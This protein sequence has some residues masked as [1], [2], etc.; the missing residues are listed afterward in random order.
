MATPV[1][2]EELPPQD[3]EMVISQKTRRSSFCC[4]PLAM[5]ALALAGVVSAQNQTVQSYPLN[6]YSR[7]LD[8]QWE[9]IKYASDGNV[10]FASSSQS[11]HH[12]ASFF[13]YSPAT[14]QVTML[15]EDITTICGEDPQTNP[16]GKIHANIQ[17]MHGWLFFTTHFGADDRPGGYTGWT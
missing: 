2:T 1:P 5:V 17:E 14:Q 8:G 9:G 4:V 10:Y 11:A 7:Y 13:K 12:G 16:Q 3:R 6:S 15:A